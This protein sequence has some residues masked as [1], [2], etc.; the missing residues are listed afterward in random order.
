MHFPYLAEKLHKKR[1]DIRFNT[2]KIVAKSHGFYTRFAL[3][4]GDKAALK[5]EMNPIE[6]FQMNYF[7]RNRSR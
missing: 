7:F 5:I 3:P 1:I 6:Y 2:L 4:L